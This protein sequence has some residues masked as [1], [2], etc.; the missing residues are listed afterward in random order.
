M[1][2]SCTTFAFGCLRGCL[3]RGGPFL[4]CR[5]H[6]LRCGGSY[7]RC[8]LCGGLFL[9]CRGSCLRCLTGCPLPR[10][11]SLVQ[12]LKLYSTFVSKLQVGRE[13]PVVLRHEVL[14]EL[15]LALFEQVTGHVTV[16]SLASI[17]SLHLETAVGCSAPVVLRSLYH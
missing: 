6:C 11:W 17:D 7:L 12:E 13:R 4:H 1:E 10:P 8:L 15:C 14:N 2:S 3:L 5:S 9:R 16:N